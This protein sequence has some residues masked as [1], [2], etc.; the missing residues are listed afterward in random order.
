MR[1]VAFPKN[2]LSNIYVKTLK[3]LHNLGGNEGWSAEDQPMK[4]PLQV[5]TSKVDLLL[6]RSSP[7]GH[8][9]RRSPVS[10]H[11]PGGQLPQL[12]LE[13]LEPPLGLRQADHAV[14]GTIAGCTGNKPPGKSF[15]LKLK[16]I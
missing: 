13:P 5:F 2:I 7:E 11:G 3:S 9:D 16:L 8:P 15:Q 6:L 12:H 10:L 1:I 14:Q 4:R